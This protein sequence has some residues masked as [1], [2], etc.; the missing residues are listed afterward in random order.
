MN[1]VRFA[2][3][4][5][6]ASGTQAM[7]SSLTISGRGGRAC[8][9]WESPAWRQ[10]G[11]INKPDPLLAVEV[12]PHLLDCLGGLS[13]SSRLTKL[14]LRPLMPPLAFCFAKTATP[15]RDIIIR[16]APTPRHPPARQHQ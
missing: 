15:V 16:S 2:R 4:T 12:A 1:A 6:A 3:A 7:A 11:D 14:N 9:L 13:L 5:V 10:A 8:P